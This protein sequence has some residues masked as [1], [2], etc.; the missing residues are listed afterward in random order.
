MAHRSQRQRATDPRDGQDI[1]VYLAQ[2]VRGPAGRAETSTYF[3]IAGDDKNSYHFMAD[4]GQHDRL[5]DVLTDLLAVAEAS[6][7]LALG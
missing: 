6:P 2:A 3:E 7:A 5:E 4:E 1:V